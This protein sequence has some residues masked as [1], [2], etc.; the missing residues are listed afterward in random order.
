MKPILEFKGEHRWLS[1]FAYSPVELNGRI[2]PTVE[3]AY[4]AAKTQD[5]YSRWKFQVIP[6][7]QANVAKK[8]G[9]EVK[10]ATPNWDVARLDVMLD[11]VRKKFKIKEYRQM[12]ISTGSATLVEGNT[13][14][15][16]FWGV[17]RGRGENH[18]GRI[19]MRV[20][21]EIN[22]ESS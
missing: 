13:W 16:Q 12:L 22:E 8:M 9:Q 11:L 19:I 4:Q 14:G 20:R 1:N 7:D 10:I 5:D 2:F 18:L 17:S 3:H 21:K 6:S 15:D